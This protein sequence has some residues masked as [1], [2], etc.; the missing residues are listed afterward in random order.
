MRTPLLVAALAAAA[1]VPVWTVAAQADVVPG[2]AYQVTNVGS[3][4]CVESLG[5][6]NGA[7]LRQQ[8]CS[9]Q[10]WK[11]TPTSDGYHT[12]GEGAVWDVSNVSTADN[13][14]VHMWQS[15]TANNQQWRPE[16]VGTG[17]YRFVNRHSGK[18]L[19]VPAATTNDVQLVQ[20][21][22][23]G[24]NAQ[25][26]RLSAANQNPGQPDFG[27][28][29]LVFD[30]SMPAST[31]QARLDDVFRQQE[32][33]QYDARRYAIMFKPGN[34][35]VDV[36]IGFFTQV[37][38]LG[39]LP[40]GVTINGQVHVEADWFQG[41]ATH[42]FWRGAENLAIRP[43][44]GT[45]TWAVSQ[46]SAMRRTKTYGN[47]QLD[48]GGW[49]SGGFLT[50]SV[51]TGQVR[52]G[53]QQQW[54][55][56]NTEWGSWTGENWN[57]VFV[58]ARNAPQTSF[59]EPPYTNVAQTPVVRE[60]PFLNV[61]GSGNYNVFVP[62][63][64][65]NSSGT[66]WASGTQQGTNIPLSQFFI[67]KPGTSA[68]T[69]NQ[70]LAAGKHLLLT[71]GI[72]QVSEPIRVTRPD[73]VVMG[74]GLAT[75][76]PTNGTMA[77]DVADV[78]G[79]KVAGLLID[80]AP[81]NSPLLMQVG[82]PGS[83]ARHQANPT[84][85]H[86][87]YVRIGG[88]AIGRATTSLV[89][90]SHD[91]IGDHLWL[92]RG[93]HS[94]GVGWDVNTADTGLIVN[95]NNVTMYGLFVEHYQKYQTIWNGQGGRTYFYQNEMPYEA[96][97]QAA[98]MNGS[99]RGYAAYKVANHVTTHEAWGLGSYIYMRYNAAVTADRAFEVPNTPGVKFHSMVT[100]SLGGNGTIQ[101][102]INNS[103]GTAT[104]GSTEAYL[105]HYPN[106]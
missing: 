77:L 78:D 82:A 74:L 68:A 6:A 38:G 45:N 28:N 15:F 26:F 73:T 24:T 72:H 66:T 94:Y 17:T 42:N 53:S 47:M 90:N 5:T 101:R 86:D 70:Q 63:L 98:W 79:V 104:A 27:P 3:G 92:W 12:V 46:A 93:D 52:S 100:V 58:G 33:G 99:T 40:D 69:M 34:Y 14:A 4:K 91:V 1:I 43:P 20:Y 76:M 41:N 55:S 39:M 89:V 21:T 48:D 18:C 11:F 87:L 2:T 30:P 16:Q 13:A 103:G 32:E 9:G 62:A 71:P 23:N 51:V 36:N 80:A 19:D 106:P 96:P 85:L 83:S 35:N 65:T 29:V 56:R 67:A 105:A 57:M 75:V 22:C 60:K 8:G 59:P 95:G 84:S 10:T 64:R 81:T 31:I 97:N 88:S 7:Q 50:D 49:S 37:L 44:S 61:D 102:I 54:L 25:L